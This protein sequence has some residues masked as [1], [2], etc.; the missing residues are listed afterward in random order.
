M[1]VS[2]LQKEERFEA[3]ARLRSDLRSQ[4]RGAK[5]MAVGEASDQRLSD[6]QGLGRRI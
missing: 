3:D 4:G 6:E 2:F 1:N 5:P